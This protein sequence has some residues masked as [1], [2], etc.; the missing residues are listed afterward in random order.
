[1]R[2]KW[3]ELCARAAVE[4]DHDKLINLVGEIDR[5]L[6]EREH[7]N[8]LFEVELPLKQRVL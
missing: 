7:T 5:M 6:R 8:Q 2:E 3:E 1:M 4:Y